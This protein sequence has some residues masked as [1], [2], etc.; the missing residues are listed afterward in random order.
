MTIRAYSRAA[1]KAQI[2]ATLAIRIQSGKTPEATMYTIARALDMRPSTHLMKILY[3]MLEDCEV[4]CK[5]SPHRKLFNKR[6]WSLP[7]G[8]YSIP[9]SLTREIKLSRAGVT[10]ERI[11]L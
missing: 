9:K 2:I 10:Y 6:V 11:L 7:A 5:I 4:E 3:E 8:S 1:R